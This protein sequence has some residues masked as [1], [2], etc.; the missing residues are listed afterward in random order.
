MVT[1]GLLD[2]SLAMEPKED[3]LLNSKF[4]KPK[5]YLLD[6]QMIQRMFVMAIPMMI[7]SITI[8]KA[9][10]QIDIVKASTMTLTVMAVFQ[11][12]NAW[13]CRHE[14]KSIF[15]MKIFS[16]KALVFSTI[17]VFLLQLLAVYHP[18][19]QKYLH[20]MGLSLSEWVLI[21]SVAG[22]IIVFEETRKLIA[23]LSR[24]L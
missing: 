1:D 8:F 7:G 22:S 15:Q 18:F 2:V 12:F 11:W 5:K 9:Y 6:W 24:G 3:G 17:G 4:F 10:Y 23:R 20:T 13:N 19:M 21:I 16:N 14:S